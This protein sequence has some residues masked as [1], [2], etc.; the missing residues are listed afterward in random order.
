MA[1]ASILLLVGSTA[2]NIYYYNRYSE[3]AEKFDVLLSE[4]TI[5]L[6]KQDAE[7]AKYNLDGQ[8]YADHKRFFDAYCG[9]DRKEQ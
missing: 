9:N 2:L 1:A 3:T 4:R 5:M 8:Q 7:R 6:A